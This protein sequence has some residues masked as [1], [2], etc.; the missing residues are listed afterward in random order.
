[1]DNKDEQILDKVKP[2]KQVRFAI[3]ATVHRQAMKI[4]KRNPR[5][6]TFETTMTELIKLGIKATKTTSI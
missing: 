3:P 4:H 6:Y 2:V 1:M 5:A